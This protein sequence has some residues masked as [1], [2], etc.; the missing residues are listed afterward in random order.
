MRKYNGNIIG[1]TATAEKLGNK[2]LDLL[3]VPALSECDTV[4]L[5]KGEGADCQCDFIIRFDLYLSVLANSNSEESKWMTA[6]ICF[7][8]LVYGGGGGVEATET[9]ND[10]RHPPNILQHEGAYK[11]RNLPQTGTYQTSSTQLV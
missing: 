7:L 11:I 4:S 1:L 2:C 9:L 8:S 3:P 6:G 5:W 10:L